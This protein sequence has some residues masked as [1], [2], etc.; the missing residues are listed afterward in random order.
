MRKFVPPHLLFNFDN[1]KLQ[2][3]IK[4]QTAKIA[5]L[6]QN[7]VLMD[8]RVNVS[9]TRLSNVRENYRCENNSTQF[10]NFNSQVVSANTS[11]HCYCPLR[12][13][14]SN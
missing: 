8:D 10:E 4:E 12:I 1:S 13:I 3:R 5:Q 9:G 7:L 14:S 2:K 6:Q 11:H